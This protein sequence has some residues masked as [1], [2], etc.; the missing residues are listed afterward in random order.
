MGFKLIR[1]TEK[2]RTGRW[3]CLIILAGYFLAAP[4]E[5]FADVLCLK[6]TARYRFGRNRII[7][8]HKVR[9]FASSCGRGY[10]PVL[11]LDQYVGTPGERGEAGP[12]GADG[13]DG[14]QGPQGAQGPAGEDG[15]IRIY[16]DGSAGS[17][18]VSGSTTL[19]AANL[20]YSDITIEPGGTLT[21]PS[22]TILR[23]SG[24]FV[25]QGTIT[26]NTFSAGGR[27]H[28]VDTSMLAVPFR[29]A[30]PG[31]ARSPAMNGS[32]GTSAGIQS[33]GLGGNGLLE[34]HAARLLAPGL[35]GGG[36]GGA[37]FSEGGAGGGALVILARGS[38][39]NS[40]IINAD[41]S[42]GGASGGGGGGGGIIILASETSISNTGNINA[43]GGNGGA[44]TTLTGP[45]GGGGGGVV[46]FIAPA[47][48]NSGTVS[49]GP[50]T[51][52]SGG[53][54]VTGTPRSA[55]GGGGASGGAGGSGG[56]VFTDNSASAGV[57]GSS[58]W[59]IET[60]ADPTS[61]F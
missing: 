40:G 49:T 59:V 3:F 21:L 7:L 10:K 25:N 38:L 52:S 48:P 51:G 14:A 31:V 42:D 28:T 30:L 60:L 46:H 58:G 12:A 24:S 20:Q 54:G 6:V 2:W 17:L 61:L 13:V 1:G 4:V 5:L 35:S 53:T 39:E 56:D 23:V 57:A 22:G 43:N 44:R 26:V 9:N 19:N 32:Y 27:T 34:A 36:G 45:G 29:P 41:G 37:G 16:G 11:D 18:S 55:G 8:R 50:G 15:S 47:I 33:G